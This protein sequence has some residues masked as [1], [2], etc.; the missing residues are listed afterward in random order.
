MI[1]MRPRECCTASRISSLCSSKST[2]GD[3]PV[4][5]TTTMP[6]VP[7]ATCQSIRFLKRGKSSFPSSCMGVTIATSE[8]VIMAGILLASDG[9]N[10]LHHRR[11]RP[12]DLPLLESQHLQRRKGLPELPG[13]QQKRRVRRLAEALVAEHECLVDQHPARRKGLRQPR[14]KRPVQIVG[15]HDGPEAVL[16]Q[17]PRTAVLQILFQE[18]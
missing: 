7:S 6:S 8:P 9:A 3:S 11:L 16:L 5:P 1:G 18:G 13:T 12:R 14:K 2:V 10:P 4:V 15:H 17:R